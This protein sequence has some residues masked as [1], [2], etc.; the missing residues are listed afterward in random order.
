MNHGI[1]E[2]VRW[3]IKARSDYQVSPPILSF[4]TC[5]EQEKHFCKETSCKTTESLSQICHIDL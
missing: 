5:L 1:P 3:L 2:D 4:H